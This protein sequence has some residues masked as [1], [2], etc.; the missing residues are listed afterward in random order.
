MGTISNV[1]NTKTSHTMVDESRPLSHGRSTLKL[2]TNLVVDSLQ[3][4]AKPASLIEDLGFESLYISER[5][6]D[7]FMQ[8]A[9]AATATDRIKLGPEIALAFPR[10]PMVLAYTSWDL[11]QATNGRFV[12]GLGTQ[13]KDYVSHCTSFARFG[14]TLENRRRC[15]SLRPMILTGGSSPGCSYKHSRLSL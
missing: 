9:V 13:V 8:L 12:L 7:P 14:S 1:F 3:D 6:H 2:S 10:N 5:K 15:T 11:Q 4:V